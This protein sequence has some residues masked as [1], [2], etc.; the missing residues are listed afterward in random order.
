IADIHIEPG[1]DLPIGV[2][3]E[4][5]RARV[6]DAFQ[7]RRNVDAIAHRVAVVLL[8]DVAKV[9]ADAEFDSP[10]LRH[11]GVALR[12]R[13]LNFDRAPHRVDHATELDDRA[14]ARPL[15]HPALVYGD[16]GIDQIA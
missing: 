4:A 11:A 5:D 2:L 10:V 13:V 6:G 8:H 3:G 12:H 7:P 1:L 16:G 15:D 14:V 9:H